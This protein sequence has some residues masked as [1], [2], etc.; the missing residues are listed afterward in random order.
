MQKLL[1]FSLAVML[2]GCQH[3]QRCTQPRRSTSPFS[4]CRVR[5]A[6]NCQQ[7]AARTGCDLTDACRRAQAKC[8]Q[9]C[10]SPSTLRCKKLGLGWKEFRVPVPKLKDRRSFCATRSCSS[11]AC[12][13]SDRPNPAKPCCDRSAADCCNELPMRPMDPTPILTLPQPGSGSNP[14]ASQWHTMPNQTQPVSSNQ[15]A[16][17]AALEHRTAVL[18]GQIREIHTMLRQRQ[19]GQLPSTEYQVPGVP[20]QQRDVIMLPP[21]GWRTMDGVPPI[22]DSNIEQTGAYRSSHGSW[23]TAANPQ[24]WPHSPQ[25]MQRRMLR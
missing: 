24:M 14:Q 10:P 4:T 21:P 5:D 12:C 2:L 9:V 18:E 22:P 25:N 23:R 1:L 13:A 17:G 7:S 16:A 6:G 11:N 20:A 8:Q 19:T 15:S 3:A